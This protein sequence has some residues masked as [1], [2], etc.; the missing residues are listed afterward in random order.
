MSITEIPSFDPPS[1]EEC[2]NTSP[3]FE[4]IQSDF[5]NSTSADERSEDNEI[6]GGRFDISAPHIIFPPIY[7]NRLQ[8]IPNTHALHTI[9]HPPIGFDYS[10]WTRVWNSQE[11]ELDGY[12]QS[13]RSIHNGTLLPWIPEYAFSGAPYRITIKHYGRNEDLPTF[14]HGMMISFSKCNGLDYRYII[15]HCLYTDD[16]NAYLKVI[17][18]DSC[19]YYYDNCSYRPPIILAI[20]KSYCQVRMHP[21]LEISQVTPTISTPQNTFSSSLWK[22]ILNKF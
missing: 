1:Y 6:F 22:R 8:S 3:F 20:P 11:Y 18:F 13:V 15:D 10:Q 17:C 9:D 12:L 2:I 7:L 4:E 19:Q 16:F 14:K 5:D 21:N